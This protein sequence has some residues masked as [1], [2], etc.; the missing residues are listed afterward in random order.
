MIFFQLQIG[1]TVELFCSDY[2]KKPKKDSWDDDKLDGLLTATCLYNRKFNLPY[3]ISSWG[4]CL[5]KERRKKILKM[6]LLPPAIA[7]LDGVFFFL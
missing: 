2:W 4:S 3:D 7:Y 5:A 6:F 1:A